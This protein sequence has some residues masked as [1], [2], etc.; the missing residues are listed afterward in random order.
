MGT[1]LIVDD[2]LPNLVALELVLEQLPHGVVRALSG[3]EALR[4]TD[5]MDLT[6]ILT[7]LKM[8]GLSGADFCARVRGGSRNRDVPIIILSGVEPDDP[9]L[10]PM[11]RLEAVR[12]VQKP[13]QSEQLLAQVAALMRPG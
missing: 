6:L 2:Y 12:F 1:L 8:K 11:L 5:A 7:D 4:I 10:S 9:A 13:Y 3:Q